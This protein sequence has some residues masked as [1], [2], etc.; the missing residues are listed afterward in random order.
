MRPIYGAPAFC[1]KL[2]CQL[3]SGNEFSWPNLRAPDWPNR[4]DP[5]MLLRGYLPA[6]TGSARG[7]GRYPTHAARGL[8]ADSERYA[9][10]GRRSFHTDAFGHQHRTADRY[11][12]TYKR[13]AFADQPANPAASHD[14]GK[15]DPAANQHADPGPQCDADADRH[16]CSDIDG[17]SDHRPNRDSK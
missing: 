11:A 12:I 1:Q 3:S 5:A 10:R 15:P 6:V 16:L 8:V 14:S 17:N 4:V 9:G 7:V 2:F 13:T